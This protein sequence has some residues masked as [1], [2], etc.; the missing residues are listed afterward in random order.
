MSLRGPQEGDVMDDDD[1]DEEEGF[2]QSASTDKPKVG[3][4]SSFDLIFVNSSFLNG[5]KG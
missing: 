2:V 3:L 5:S 4:F 1:D